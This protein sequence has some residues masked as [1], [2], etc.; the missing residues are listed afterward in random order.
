MT[1][2]PRFVFVNSSMRSSSNSAA[3]LSR[4][5][6]SWISWDIIDAPGGPMGLGVGRIRGPIGAGPRTGD[7]NPVATTTG[8]RL[9]TR[10]GGDFRWTMRRFLPDSRNCRSFSHW[11]SGSNI[12]SS[13]SKISGE[14]VR[15]GE[16][17][18]L[19]L[20][21]GDRSSRS[22]LGDRRLGDR[23]L[24]GVSRAR[25]R[26]NPPLGSSSCR[27]PIFALVRWKRYDRMS[28][29]IPCIEAYLS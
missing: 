25:D 24:G 2:I 5:R 27:R 22:R 6:D 17:V 4:I 9:G 29:S 26:D 15:L 28:S 18:C 8:D 1:T 20:R 16:G 21:L 14:G 11:T 3:D 13:G 23:R 10:A 12:S 19:R 7:S